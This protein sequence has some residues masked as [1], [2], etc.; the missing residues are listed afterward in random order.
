MANTLSLKVSSRMVETRP[1]CNERMTAA[2]RV[3]WPGLG[4]VEDREVRPL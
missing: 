2:S 1:P 3:G 4:M